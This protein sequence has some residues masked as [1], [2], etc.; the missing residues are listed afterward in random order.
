VPKEQGRKVVATNRKARHDYHIEDVFEAGLVLT[1]TEVKSLRAGRASLVDGF[2]TVSGGEIWLEGV[3]IPEYAL[4]TWTN[5]PRSPEASPSR[6]DRPAGRAVREKGLTLVPLVL[7]FTDGRAKVNSVAREAQP[8]QR[9]VCA[10]ARPQRPTAHVPAHQPLGTRPA[11]PARATETPPAPPVPDRRAR[12]YGGAVVRPL[13]RTL[14]G[15]AA[16]AR[17]PCSPSA[18][19]AARAERPV[20]L[21]APAAGAATLSAP[22]LRRAQAPAVREITPQVTMVPGRNASMMVQEQIT[23][24]FGDNQRHGI[25][26]TIPVE[27]ARDSTHVREYPLTDIE[28]SSPSGAPSDLKVDKG[29]VTTLRIGNPDRT[30]SGVQTYVIRYTV[31]GVINNF[32]DHQELY[33]NA[34]GSEWDVPIASA[35]ATVEGPAEVQQVACFE[36]AQGSTQQCTAAKASTG[37]TPAPPTYPGLG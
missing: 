8:R 24:D 29:P 13:I 34:I 6:G 21:P 15:R 4:G 20:L 32:A 23:Y 3:H 19:G 37:A 7:Y 28:V 10:N 11:R 18:P 2:A 14:H 9:Q 26:R 22:R 30:V 33:W 5:R 12:H 27:F 31:G 35:L 1:G 16:P 36:G 17:P 25:M